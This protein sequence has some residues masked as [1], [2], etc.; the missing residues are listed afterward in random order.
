MDMQ[1]SILGPIRSTR[2][3][4]LLDAIGLPAGK[5]VFFLDIHFLVMLVVSSLN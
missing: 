1:A 3:E 2:N 5:H 4:A